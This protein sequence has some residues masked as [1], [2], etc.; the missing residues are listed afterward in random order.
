MPV[1][2]N[3]AGKYLL[4]RQKYGRC[5]DEQRK[6]HAPKMPRDTSIPETLPRASMRMSPATDSKATEPRKT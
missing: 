4:A 2:R 1:L 3:K 6:A 5:S